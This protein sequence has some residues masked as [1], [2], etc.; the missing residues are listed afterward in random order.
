MSI[1]SRFFGKKKT[2]KETPVVLKRKKKSWSQKPCIGGGK[3]PLP[4]VV[5]KD[6]K[7]LRQCSV[8]SHLG[9]PSRKRGLVAAH[10]A[11]SVD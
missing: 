1:L 4:S 11:R 9:I 6:G 7:Q 8:C 10:F 2:P 5:H 3:K